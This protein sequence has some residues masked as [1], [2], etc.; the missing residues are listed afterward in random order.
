MSI[1]S[2]R[3]RYFNQLPECSIC[4]NKI[5]PNVKVTLKCKHEFHKLC[6]ARW[7]GNPKNERDK[8][9]GCP[10]CRGPL[11]VKLEPGTIKKDKEETNGGTRRRKKSKKIKS[12]KLNIKKTKA[13]KLK[14]KK[15]KNR[16]L[17]TR[18]LRTIIR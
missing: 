11:E 10:L 15:N 2:P 5:L 6:L 14:G 8:N 7:A 16:K 4:L 3:S 17:N 13:R 12:R 18:K 1:P 9:K